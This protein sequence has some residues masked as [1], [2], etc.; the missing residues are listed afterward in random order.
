MSCGQ[1]PV[2]SRSSASARPIFERCSRSIVQAIANRIATEAMKIT[3][4]SKKCE[5]P[6]RWPSPK[7]CTSQPATAIR[8][9]FI[10]TVIGAAASNSTALCHIGPL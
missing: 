8:I 5:K 6:S 4:P 9:E 3:Q 1:T 10:S 7:Y 2:K